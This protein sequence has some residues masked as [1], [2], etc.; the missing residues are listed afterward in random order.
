M[1]ADKKQIGGDH[2]M[3]Y[4][5]MQPVHVLKRYL[6][7]EEFRGWTKGNA[8]VYLLRERDKG[9]DQDILKAGHHIELWNDLNK[10]G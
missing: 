7:E 5:K 1:S 3:Q 8:I 4:G 2:Y 10:D 9:G 6:T